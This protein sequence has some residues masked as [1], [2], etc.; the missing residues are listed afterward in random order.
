MGFHLKHESRLPSTDL[1]SLDAG[2]KSGRRPIWLSTRAGHQWSTSSLHLWV[3]LERTPPLKEWARNMPRIRAK[4][5][6]TTDTEEHRPEDAF[7]RLPIWALLTAWA[8]T[9]FSPGRV[10]DTD[11]LNLTCPWF[12]GRWRKLGPRNHSD[13]R[14]ISDGDLGRVTQ[15]AIFSWPGT[16]PQQLI[17]PSVA[18]W[19]SPILTPSYTRK[20]VLILWIIPNTASELTNWYTSSKGSRES[21]SITLRHRFDST[22][23]FNSIWG[24]ETRLRGEIRHLAKSKRHQYEPSCRSQQM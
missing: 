3:T 14:P 16:H 9:F 8:S 13:S 6:F 23:P 21:A 24:T 12:K 17:S 19:I 5:H 18:A 4:A 2:H 20:R 1:S 11:G 10:P 15:S 7:Q 22:A